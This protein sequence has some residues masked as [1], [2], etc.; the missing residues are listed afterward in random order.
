M[1]DNFCVAPFIHLNNTPRGNIHP[2][3]VW[4]GDSVGTME[5][6][7]LNVWKNDKMV[8]LRNQFINNERPWECNKCWAVEDAGSKS[9][10]RIRASRD[11]KQHT[12]LRETLDAPIWLQLKL[13]AKCNLACR[14]CS[15]GSSNK[16]LKETAITAC[17]YENN[18]IKRKKLEQEYIR[19]RQKQSSFIYKNSFWEELKELT[20]SLEF[21]TFTGGE[22]LLIVEH[23]Q[24]LEWCVEQGYAKNIYLDYITNGTVGLDDYKK[25]LWSNFKHI[26]LIVS[27]DGIEKL[28]E[29]IRTNLN[30]E[31]VK[32]NIFDYT[33]YGRKNQYSHGVTY[34]VSIY[35]IYYMGESL[36]F[37][38]DNN[39]TVNINFLHH[40]EWQSIRNLS[41]NVKQKV[42]E[43]CSLPDEVIN[44]MDQ[45]PTAEFNFC[46]KL[47][48]QESIYHKATRKTIDYEKLF[49]EWWN[50]LK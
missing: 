13:G 35:N 14:T 21:I 47:K 40:P 22:P 45:E 44:F 50:I 34:L 27:M 19:S 10:F 12:H 15:A 7:I 32:Q 8:T 2:C 23:Y 24:Y 11:F 49:P 29:Y 39:I 33:E 31:E 26:E 18:P 5:E 46:D 25:D 9:S 16:W 42:K 30:W 20:P 48:K 28:A 1:P 37:Y 3:C 36:K 4:S 43:N 6:G 17:N 38:K 41:N